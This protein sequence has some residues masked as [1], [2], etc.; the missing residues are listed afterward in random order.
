MRS[1]LPLQWNAV[2][3]YY[4]VDITHLQS[5]QFISDSKHRMRTVFSFRYEATVYITTAQ[6]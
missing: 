3:I 2:N 6:T 5:S 4:T 1:M